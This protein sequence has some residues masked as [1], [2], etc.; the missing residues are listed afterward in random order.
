M[1]LCEIKEQLRG[2]G[3]DC[4]GIFGSVA[5]GRADILSDI[6]I[7]IHTTPEFVACFERAK[8]FIYLDNLHRKLEKRFERKVDLC[9]KTGLQKGMEG[10]IYA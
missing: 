1:Y 3:I 7:I 2:V 9:D 4:V 6:D 8:G 10:V 5:R